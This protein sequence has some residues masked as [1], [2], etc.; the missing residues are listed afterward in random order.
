[1]EVP[2]ASSTT[3]ATTPAC[4]TFTNNNAVLNLNSDAIA[5]GTLTYAM[6]T[7][8]VTGP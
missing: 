1:M 6:D 7:S 5:F 8:S 3:R 2:R 4:D